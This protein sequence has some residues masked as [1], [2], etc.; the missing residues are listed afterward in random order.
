[1]GFGFE[2]VKDRWLSRDRWEDFVHRVNQYEAEQ[3]RAEIARAEKV[4]EEQAE[5]EGSA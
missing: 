1:M 3:A 5:K 4:I 2:A